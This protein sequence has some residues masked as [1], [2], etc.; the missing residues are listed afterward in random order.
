MQIGMSLT[1]AYP[2]SLD[3]KALMDGLIEQV[4]SMAELGFASL[5][6]G[7]HHVTPNHYFQALPTMSHLA[8]HS[9]D[10]RLIPLFL[11]PFYNP[12]LL[13]EQLATLDVIN[14]GRTTVICALGHQP[15]AHAAFQTSQRVRVSRFVETFEIMRLLWSKDNATYEGKHYAFD[16]VSINP[17]PM[18]G[19][20]PMWMGANA[21]PAIRRTARIADA[22]VI[23]PSWIPPYVEERMAF[24]R[25]ALD[26][27]GRSDAVSEVI[28]RRDLHLS[29]SEAAARKE[30]ERLF[31]EGYR[32]FGEWEMRE[33]LIVGGPEEC[34]TT[35]ERFERMGVT[36]VLFR[37]AM[38][39]PAQAAQTIRVL[40]E[41]VIPHFRR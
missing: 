20:L 5:S 30:A 21:D 6:L 28:L 4:K 31:R 8:A 22:W 39:E 23:N 2:R 1:T 18:K 37:C 33:S 19:P 35:L 27:V 15:E 24:Y 7:D 26:K 40:G 32:G 41:H 3:A 25:E 10:M 17:K 34:I 9:G 13:A 38:D 12:I 14:G 16:G 29:D 36:H 11:L